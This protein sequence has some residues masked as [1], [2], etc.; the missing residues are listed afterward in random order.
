MS[1]GHRKGGDPAKQI[2]EVR[3]QPG[4]YC[5]GTQVGIC[6]AGFVSLEG[7]EWYTRKEGPSRRSERSTLSKI[8]DKSAEERTVG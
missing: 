8:I 4:K 2:E 7:P 1:R 6:Q 3:E 5:P